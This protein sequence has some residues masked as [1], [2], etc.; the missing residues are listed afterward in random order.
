MHQTISGVIPKKKK[1]LDRNIVL[2]FLEEN[3]K[4]F[5]NFQSFENC[6]YRYDMIVNDKSF[7]YLNKNHKVEYN[8]L[9]D[10][11]KKEFND[12]ERIY[13]KLGNYFLSEFFEFKTTGR[14]SNLVF[15]KKDVNKFISESL[16]DSGIKELANYI[17]KNCSMENSV[18]VEE[19]MTDC[20]IVKK[21]DN[22]ILN[23]KYDNSFLGT[24]NFIKLK[25]Y[26]FVVY[27]GFVQ[28]ISEIHH[29]LEKSNKKNIP[30]VLFCKGMSKDVKN[31]IIV[32][33]KN[34]KINVQPVSFEI[35]E[36]SLNIMHDIA[37]LHDSDVVNI[38][39]GSTISKEVISNKKIGKEIILSQN[40]IQ[41]VP[42]CT[43]S[44]IYSHKN[45][46]KKRFENT[47]NAEN[48]KLIG[49]RIKTFT[50]KSIK[51][52][53]P[54]TSK[55]HQIRE[56]D[57]L[58]RFLQNVEKKMI[59]IE[60]FENFSYYVP[61]KYIDFAKEKSEKTK[62]IFSKIEKLILVSEKT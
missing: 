52:Y 44:A 38:F 24:N 41:I 62:E 29:M 50:G 8:S 36:N 55:R 3:K 56:I 37:V 13:P 21:E 46:L 7:N 51:I 9:I 61:K 15:S 18:T 11:I 4:E 45:F 60:N 40:K 31:T 1:I 25:N 30:Y 12:C 57:Y 14:K 22:H 54:K 23:L 28:E 19:T 53:I 49:E 39:N 35:D 33:N 27:D 32:N 10:I 2:N 17:F 20:F 43:E 42:I 48:K 26:R 16:K 47:S 6:I 5:K 34:G 59:R 58:L